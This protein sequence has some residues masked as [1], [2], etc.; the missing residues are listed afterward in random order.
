MLACGG[1][2]G[3]RRPE[4]VDC[5]APGGADAPHVDRVQ[6]ERR[7]AFDAEHDQQEE[8]LA[9]SRRLQS[10]T[11]QVP[12]NVSSHGPILR[13]GCNLKAGKWRCGAY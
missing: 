2:G 12:T 1:F 5:Y 6:P 9:T 7:A 4:A 13:Y 11:F 8:L 10:Q 3:R